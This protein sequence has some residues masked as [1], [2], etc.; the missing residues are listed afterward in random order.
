MFLEIAPFIFNYPYNHNIFSKP[1][2]DYSSTHSLILIVSFAVYNIK[3]NVFSSAYFRFPL[4]LYYLFTCFSLFP[5]T[6]NI[7]YF[8]L[9]SICTLFI[10]CKSPLVILYSPFIPMHS[11]FCLRSFFFISILVNSL[12]RGSQPSAAFN[13]RTTLHHRLPATIWIAA[14]HTSHWLYRQ[15]LLCIFVFEFDNMLLPR[16]NISLQTLFISVFTFWLY[17]IHRQCSCPR[18][19]LPREVLPSRLPLP[20]PRYSPKRTLSAVSQREMWF[21]RS[22]PARGRPSLVQPLFRFISF[23]PFPWCNYLSKMS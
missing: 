21:V 13:R 11:V 10:M 2:I 17:Y 4:P 23:P 18:P 14:L 16:Q 19:P 5:A 12:Y 8:L 20:S 7:H 15:R 9:F 3:V 1:N 6:L 22:P